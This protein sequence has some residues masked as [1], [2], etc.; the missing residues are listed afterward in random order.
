[1]HFWSIVGLSHI[2]I[3]EI[4]HLDSDYQRDCRKDYVW[5]YFVIQ[6][7]S[8]CNVKSYSYHQT[9]YRRIIIFCCSWQYTR[10]R[11]LRHWRN[12]SGFLLSMIFTNNHHRSRSWMERFC[13]W[14]GNI[15]IS[16]YNR[17]V[18][19]ELDYSAMPR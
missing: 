3:L 8:K 17:I 12:R 13:I 18:V 15:Q 11:A 6:K 2:I 10:V 9:T 1:M 14:K 19:L 7:I 16:F 4:R 5:V